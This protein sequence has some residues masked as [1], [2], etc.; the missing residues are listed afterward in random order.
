MGDS[1]AKHISK[2]LILGENKSAEDIV[3]IYNAYRPPGTDIHVYAKII[4]VDD[5]EPFDDKFW[6]KLELTSGENSFSSKTKRGD[7]KEY[8]YGIPSIS[9]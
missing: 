9:S 8:I 5:P 1:K 4:N 6:T 7:F 3:V 2:P